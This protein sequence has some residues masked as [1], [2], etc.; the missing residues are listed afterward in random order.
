M[1]CNRA[2]AAKAVRGLL[3]VVFALLAPIAVAQ[4]LGT[5]QSPILTIEA[6]RL[7]SGSQFGQR[8]AREREADTAVLSAENRRIEAELTDEERALTDRRAGMEPDAFRVLADAFDEKVQDIRRRQDAKARA[9]TQTEERDR[10]AFLQAAAPVLEELMRE[11]GAAV[12]IERGSV[13]LSLNATDI[14][15]LAIERID[16]VIGDG[17]AR[18]SE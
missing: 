12:I 18:S 15:D 10:V 17:A 6:D 8:I 11:A 16:A 2:R 4:Q 14:T 5:V 1:S 3:T 13:F 9:L 7:F